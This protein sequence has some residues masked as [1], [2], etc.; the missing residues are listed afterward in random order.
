M[1]SKSIFLD[2]LKEKKEAEKKTTVKIETASMREKVKISNVVDK[3]DGEK[4]LDREEILKKIGKSQKK[5]SVLV[6]EPEKITI[7]PKKDDIKIVP[8][9][10]ADEVLKIALT[11]ELKAVEWTEV[12]K[13][14]D[15]KKEEKSQ[16]SIQ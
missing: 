1:A 4:R 12:E 11:K 7:P 5:P 2:K 13:L 15:T 6:V 3:R 10:S 8:V 9:E 16:A 14:S